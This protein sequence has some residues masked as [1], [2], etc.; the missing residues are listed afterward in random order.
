MNAPRRPHFPGT[1]GP[2]GRAAEAIGREH[3]RA[4]WVDA[5][6]PSSK[7]LRRSPGAQASGSRLTRF[8]VHQLL[9]T[10]LERLTQLTSRRWS[11]GSAT[12]ARSC[13]ERSGRMGAPGPADAA[14]TPCGAGVPDCVNHLKAQRRTRLRIVTPTDSTKPATAPSPP[15]AKLT[16]LAATAP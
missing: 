13:S 6:W 4:G 12:L 14:T 1:R 8:I 16:P 15:H 9:M 10:L 3:D 5:S 11:P 2:S 7:Y